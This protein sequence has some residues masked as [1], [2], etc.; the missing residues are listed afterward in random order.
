[1]PIRQ[2]SPTS[3]S[4]TSMPSVVRFSPNWPSRISR[5]SSDLP[6]VEVLA[7]ER[8]D[9]LV[10]ATVVPGVG[11]LV[12]LQAEA[13]DPHRA[14]DGRLSIDVRP[15]SAHAASRGV[16]TLTDR[17]RASMRAIVPAP[18][19]TTRTDKRQAGRFSTGCRIRWVSFVA[20]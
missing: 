15:I 5:P 7:G 20:L 3:A 12:A 8:V 4:L 14:V 16:P 6:G 1:M 2:R 18:A 19:G 17:T 13:A 11:D 10:G 9:R